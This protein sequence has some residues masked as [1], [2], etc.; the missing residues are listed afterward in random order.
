MNLYLHLKWLLLQAEQSAIL[1]ARER[2]RTVNITYRHT[3]SIKVEKLSEPASTFQ[4]C[5]WYFIC[6]NVKSFFPENIQ[7]ELNGGCS[8]MKVFLHNVICTK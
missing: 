4:T 8:N 7:N 2:C 1:L 5:F 3:Y 6:F